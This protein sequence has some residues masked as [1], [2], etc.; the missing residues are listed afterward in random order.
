MRGFR[1]LFVSALLPLALLRADFVPLAND[2]ALK[3]CAKKPNVVLA[4]TPDGALAVSIHTG[5]ANYGW[6]QCAITSNALSRQAVGVYGRFRAERSG[7]ASLGLALILRR[8]GRTDYYACSQGSLADS[9]VQCL[10]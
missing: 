6:F 3:A 1:L 10:V 8:G 4:R 9:L 7:G 5:P 2:A